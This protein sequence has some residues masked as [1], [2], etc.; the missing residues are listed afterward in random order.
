[1]G[2][3][4][5]DTSVRLYAVGARAW[6]GDHRPSRSP[7]HSQTVADPAGGPPG[8]LPTP[9]LSS[10]PRKCGGPGHHRA[11]G[12]GRR[13]PWSQDSAPRAPLQSAVS[14][15]PGQAFSTNVSMTFFSP[16]LSKLTTSLLPSTARTAP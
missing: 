5:A 9:R 7:N 16:A 8:L 6:S 4:P 10:P 12:S 15:S 13:Q 14:T 3:L 11:T 2:P 1:R